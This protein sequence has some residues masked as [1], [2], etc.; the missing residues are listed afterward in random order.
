MDDDIQLDEK[1]VQKI[2]ECVRKCKQSHD[3]GYGN[4]DPNGR[5]CTEICTTI[6]RCYF[7]KNLYKKNAHASAQIHAQQPNK[8]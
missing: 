3:L 2:A 4:G 8:N 5:I 6:Y 7:V 1:S